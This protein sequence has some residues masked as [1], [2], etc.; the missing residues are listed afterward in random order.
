MTTCVYC[1]KDIDEYG[2]YRNHICP[3]LER[4]SDASYPMEVCERCRFYIPE[5]R[6][7]PA[8]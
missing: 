6:E 2:D 3:K 8:P 1:E 4:N 5:G 7:V